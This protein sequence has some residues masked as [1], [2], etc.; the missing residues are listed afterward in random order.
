MKTIYIK[1]IKNLSLALGFL[2]LFCLA[3]CKKD[4]LDAKP[5]QALIVPGTVQDYQALLDNNTDTYLFNTTQPALC[6]TMSDDYFVS[7]ASW[8]SFGLVQDRNAYVWAR[9]IYEGE[10]SFDWD[11]CYKRILHAN[12]ILDGIEK[13]AKN[14]ANTASWNNVKGSALFYRSFDFFNLAQEFCKT[15]DKSTAATDLGIVLKLSSNLNDK[16]SRSTVA[17]T[18]SQVINDLLMA[19]KLLPVMQ[20]FPSR[21]SSVAAYGLLARVYLIMGD[22]E[23]AK[24]YAEKSLGL[25][26]ELIDYN[27]LSLTDEPALPRFNKEVTFYS[28][29]NIF[30]SS[31]CYSPYVN[32]DST[33]YNTYSSND[34]RKA[35]YFKDVSGVITYKGGYYNDYSY[36]GGLQTDE[37]YLISAECNARLGALPEALKSLNTLLNTRWVTGTFTPYTATSADAL[38]PQIL[39]ERRKE[40]IFRSLR[41]PDLRRLNK[42]PRFAK[43]LT[44]NLDGVIYTLPPNDLRYVLPIPENEIKLSGIEQNPR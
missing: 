44:R 23:N 36:S 38:L 2:S 19:A 41:W 1:H 8:Q 4:W 6:E 29:L 21:P 11:Y 15:Y 16:A 34:L 24:L 25:Y 22:Y 3:S 43:T 17:Q 39:L 27:T 7:K 12:V 20:R 28:F 26:G 13:V 30:D 10:N 31:N 5:D 18:Y 14:D 42:E 33:L 35:I 40:L 32:I 9:E 37:M